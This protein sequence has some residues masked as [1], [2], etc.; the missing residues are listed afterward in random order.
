MGDTEAMEEID[1]VYRDRAR[2]QPHRWRWPGLHPGQPG[3]TA[4]RAQAAWHR[5][6]P[7]AGPRAPRAGR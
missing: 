1:R 2:P 3:V 7:P 4:P 6:A 5:T